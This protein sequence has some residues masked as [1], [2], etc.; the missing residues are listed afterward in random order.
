MKKIIFALA[1]SSFA[2][3]TAQ[4][5][6]KKSCCAN[7]KECKM[8]NKKDCKTHKACASHKSCK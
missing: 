6:P 1:I 2:F 4:Q 8:K 7:K 5:A 3:G